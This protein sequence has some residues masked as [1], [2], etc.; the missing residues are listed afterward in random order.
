MSDQDLDPATATNDELNNAA[1]DIEN[2]WDDVVNEA[3]DW[4]NAD[5]NA[6]TEAYDELYWAVHGS[7]VITGRQE[8]RGSGARVERVPA[9]FQGNI[10]WLR[11]FFDLRGATLRR[12]PET[13]ALR[14]PYHSGSAP[15][16]GLNRGDAD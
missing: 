11:L 8:P 4:A 16:T 14:G 10:R 1:N 15:L 5:D 3:E 9:G 13:L 2:A 7:P 6:L 12:E